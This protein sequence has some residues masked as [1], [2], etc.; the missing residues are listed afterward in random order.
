MKNI[1]YQ[2]G[3]GLVEV[4][5]SLVLLGVAILGYTALQTRSISAT[6]ESALRANALTIMSDL[7]DS[8]RYNIGGKARYQTQL[9]AFTDAFSSSGTATKPSDNCG[10]Y[11]GT[12]TCTPNQQADIT[13][14][15]AAQAAYAN[16]FTLKMQD[17]PGTNQKIQCL[18]AA[19]DDTKPEIGSDDDDCVKTDGSY[20]D[21]SQ[22]MVMEII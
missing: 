20:V 10:L 16:G 5:V 13:A 7:G 18:I 8:I 17:C 12:S 15:N 14:Y 19:W 3:V 9:N 21:G 4:L 22:C 1:K 2:Q 11:G 6:A